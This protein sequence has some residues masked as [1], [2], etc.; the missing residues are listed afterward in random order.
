[1]LC[2][3]R[4]PHAVRTTRCASSTTARVAWMPMRRRRGP[5]RGSCPPPRLAHSRVRHRWC[6]TTCRLSSLD[7]IGWHQ[8]TG[9]GD[10]VANPGCD[11]AARSCAMR[12]PRTRVMC[13]CVGFRSL[14]PCRSNEPARRAFLV[15]DLPTEGLT[16]GAHRHP[17]RFR[18]ASARRERVAGVP[19][20]FLHA[21]PNPPNLTPEHRRA[22]SCQPL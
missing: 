19:L 1:M 15:S 10:G 4:H 13:V 3:L 7:P 2:R 8:K 16:A 18:G 11:R 5:S 20:F 22:S 21:C 14:A 6:A 17:R 12:V 9:V